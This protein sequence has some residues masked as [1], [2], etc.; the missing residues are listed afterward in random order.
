[1]GYLKKLALFISVIILGIFIIG[2]DS[3]SDTAEKAKEDS[4]EE[5]IKKSFAK[6]LDMYPIKNLEDLYDK[7]GYRDGEFKKGDKGTW[8]LLTSFS[9]SNKPGEI[10]DEGMVLY[11]N[12]NTKKA[13]GYYFVNKIYDDISK[14]QN[15]KKYRV[16]LKN[17]KIILLDNVEDEKLKQ[18]IENFKFFSQYADFKD[19]KNYQDG[20]ITTNENVP[21]YEAEYKRNNSDENVKKLREKYP[22]TTKQS[23][24]L[25]LHIDG[26]IKGSSVGY[27]QIEY[28]FSKEKDD[29]T[30]MSDFLNFGPSHSK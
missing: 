7:E 10:D 21:Y 14:N 22:I 9:K 28:T 1:M 12:R 17:N 8:T 24:I 30:F 26:D 29:E 18:K 25:K 4:K 27:K 23:P 5:Q 13:T 19:L 11:L 3:S 20:S 6:T 2:C 15:E 16:E